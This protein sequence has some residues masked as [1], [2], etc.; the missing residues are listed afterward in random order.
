MFFVFGVAAFAD[1]N[2]CIQSPK[3]GTIKWNFYLVASH[4]QYGGDVL[5][6]AWAHDLPLLRDQ[7]RQYF[8]T[9]QDLTGPFLA[10]HQPQLRIKQYYYNPLASTAKSAQGLC[11]QIQSWG[12]LDPE[13]N[14]RHI[15]VT[16]MTGGALVHEALQT[17]AAPLLPRD[18]L[19][20][21]LIVNGVRVNYNSR[22]LVLVTTPDMNFGYR[23]PAPIYYPFGTFDFL[24]NVAVDSPYHAV[25]RPYAIGAAPL[26]VL[27]VV[28]NQDIVSAYPTSHPTRY[29]WAVDP[30]GR[31]DTSTSDFRRDVMKWAARFPI[32]LCKKSYCEAYPA[33]YEC[34]CLTTNT[35]PPDCDS[36]F[37][38]MVRVRQ[39]LTV[40]TILQPAQ[41]AL[42]ALYQSQGYANETPL[43]YE[44][45][46]KPARCG[47]G[48]FDP[49]LGEECD[50]GNLVDDDECSNKCKKRV[51]LCGDLKVEGKEECDTAAPNI[52][53]PSCM[54]KLM[55]EGSMFETGVRCVNC[56]CVF[57]YE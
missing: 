21:G 51:A 36:P 12:G 39:L 48:F 10:L 27:N 2:E 1:D 54:A 15:F 56:K 57:T 44:T 34:R 28:L 4:A 42:D 33:T 9:P 35:P 23:P 25:T 45:F 49:H 29:P 5:P 43:R 16:S 55:F 31:L 20:G 53:G 41:P 8:S 24:K 13:N 38:P 6:A 11:D 26:R 47:D 32:A 14:D 37:P 17:C 50:D 52:P 18:M 19:I 30:Q 7:W 3:N 22:V 46:K 40:E